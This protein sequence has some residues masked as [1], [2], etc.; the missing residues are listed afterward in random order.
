MSKVII[1]ENV[2]KGCAIC[3]S[4][5]P[6]KILSLSESRTNSAGYF[7]AEVLED[8]CIGCC[9]CAIMCPDS[10]ITIRK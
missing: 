8:K 2:C 3:V 5:C 1:D 4:V 7:I 9:S 10:A 6:V